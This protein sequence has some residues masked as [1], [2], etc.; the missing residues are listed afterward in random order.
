[1][2]KKSE[3]SE[4]IRIGGITASISGSGDVCVSTF[5]P[6]AHLNK[7]EALTLGKHLIKMA[8]YKPA[9]WVPAPGDLFRVQASG[10]I[11]VRLLKDMPN[12]PNGAFSDMR[13]S[14]S[15]RGKIGV[16]Y[17]DGNTF[18]AATFDDLKGE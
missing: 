4:A 2:T 16:A 7:A 18:F 12:C 8:E 9:P 3:K 13:L 11:Y 17:I 15:C 6:E 14:A 5:D 1:M 10:L